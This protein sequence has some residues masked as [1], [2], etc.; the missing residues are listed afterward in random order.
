MFKHVNRDLAGYGG[1]LKIFNQKNN[2]KYV[3]K[4]EQQLSIFERPTLPS[5]S[6][7]EQKNLRS[8]GQ[9]KNSLLRHQVQTSE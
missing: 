7:E 3:K 9:L 5:E 4:Y 1:K 6:G 2:L 8:I